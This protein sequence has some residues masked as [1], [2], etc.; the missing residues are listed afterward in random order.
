MFCLILLAGV[1]ESNPMDT[2]GEGSQDVSQ[3][4]Y[5]DCK[6]IPWTQQVMGLKVSHSLS[7]ETVKQSHGHSR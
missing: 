2:A 5:R 6:A 4:S 3:F 7:T 1:I